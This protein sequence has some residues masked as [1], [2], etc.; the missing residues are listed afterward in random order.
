MVVVDPDNAGAGEVYPFTDAERC[1][2][3]REFEL[4]CRRLGE[5]YAEHG[6]PVAGEQFRSLRVR[7]VASDLRAGHALPPQ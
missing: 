3:L 5:L 1:V 7:S 6:D 2:Q 4:L